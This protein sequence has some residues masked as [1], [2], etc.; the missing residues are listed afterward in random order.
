MWGQMDAAH[1]G[2]GV[3][4]LRFELPALVGGDGLWASVTSYPPGEQGAG[5]RLR[6][7][8]LQGNGFRPACEVIYCRKA[9]SEAV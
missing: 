8:V 3:E 7:N 9:V 5:Y 6:R 4:E 2:Q 1:V